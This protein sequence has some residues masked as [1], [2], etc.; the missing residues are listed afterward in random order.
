MGTASSYG[1]S[2]PRN[3]LLPS[4]LLEPAVPP[5][6]LI[7]TSPSDV[8]GEDD[9]GQSPNNPASPPEIALPVAVPGTIADF[10]SSRGNFTRFARSGAQDRRAL[11]RALSSYVQGSGG[12]ARAARRMGSARSAGAGLLGFLSDAANRGVAEALRSLDLPALAGQP[13]AEIFAALID[14]FCPEGGTIDE[15]VAREAFVE[16]IIDLAELGIETIVDLAADRMPA[17]FESFVTHAIEAR[18]END[19]GLK[20]VSLPTNPAAAQ[21]VQGVLRD[22]IQRAVHDVIVRAVDLRRLTQQHIGSWVD[23]VYA[24]AFTLLQVYAEAEAG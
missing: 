16:M 12:G 17:L 4:W 15:G 1:G 13:P 7:Q 19:I 20:A 11:G 21:R 8:T 24:R 6:E 18:L 23:G 14:V 22:F 9:P 5:E 2:A 10:G 3:P